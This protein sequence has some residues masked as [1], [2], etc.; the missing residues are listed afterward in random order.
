L[1]EGTTVT[2]TPPTTT[3]TE[4]RIISVEDPALVKDSANH[5]A[6]AVIPTGQW[7]RHDPFLL[8]MQDTF[9]VGA[10]GMHPHRG[11]ETITYV[12]EGHLAHSDNRG[13]AG[14]LGP[15]DIQFMT[16]GSGI[17]HLEEPPAGEQVALLQLWLNLPAA[18]KM[19]EPRY[20]DLCGVDMPRRLANGAE[21]TVYSGSSGGVTASTLNHVPVTIVAARLE[22]GASVQQDLPGSYNGFVHVLEGEGQF[23]SDLVA[24]RPGQTLWVDRLEADVATS[25]TITAITDLRVLLAAGRPLHEPVAAAGPFV[26]NTEA[27]LREAFADYHAGRFDP[28]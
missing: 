14:L 22:A 18:A 23:G 15:G 1:D 17:V 13:N 28:Q 9:G 11:I 24:G 16:A 27:Q 21:L 20:Q 2:S 4:R 12:I 6:R 7:D 3:A 8:M 26:M 5:R 25:L 19:T 10:F